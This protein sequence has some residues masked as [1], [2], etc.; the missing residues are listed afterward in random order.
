MITVWHN[1]GLWHLP[2]MTTFRFLDG[3]F[4]SG[5]GNVRL[6]FGCVAPRFCLMLNFVMCVADHNWHSTEMV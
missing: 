2:K 6:T 5:V 1:S 4:F 3:V